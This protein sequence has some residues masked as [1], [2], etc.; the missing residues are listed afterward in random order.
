MFDMSPKTMAFV[1]LA[2]LLAFSATAT[3]T[4][5]FTGESRSVL[6]LHSYHPTLTWTQ[7][8]QHGIETGFANAL[9]DISF[10]VEFMDTKRF[11]N[12]VNYDNLLQTYQHKF[13]DR[14]PDIVIV[15]DNNGLDFL[16][17]HAAQLFPDTPIV[18]CG[19]NNYS[20]QLI[21]GHPLFTGIAEEVA[22]GETIKIALAVQPGLERLYA[23]GA[24]SATWEHNKSLLLRAAEPFRKR[25]KLIIVEGLDI[26]LARMHIAGLGPG[27]AVILASS[28]RDEQGELTSFEQATHEISIAGNVPVY[29]CWDFQLGFGILG[30]KLISGQAQGEAAAELALRILSGEPVSQVHVVTKSPNRI[31]FDHDQMVRFN[32]A[33][34]SLPPGS[35][36]I[37]L[38]YSFYVQNR[39][40][41][42]SLLGVLLLLVGIIVALIMSILQRRQAR[43]LL[44]A[45]EESYRSIY[46]ATSDAII[47]CNMESGHVLDVNEPMLRMFRCDAQT[48]LDA[49]L[50][51]L[52]A[53]SLEHEEQVAMMTKG[54]IEGSQGFERRIKR[55]DETLFWAELTLRNFVV[56]GQPRMLCIVRDTT[57]RR[58]EEKI[59][60]GLMAELKDKNSELERFA[61]TVSHDLK[62]PIITIRGFVDLLREG[63]KNESHEQVLIDLDRVDS[64]AVRMN[65]LLDELLDLSRIGRGT[66]V[67]EEINISDLVHEAIELVFGQLSES[68]GK[69]H[70]AENFPMVYGERLRLLEIFQNLIGN[71]TKFVEP[72]QEPKIEV[73]VR[74]ENG[75]NVF[76]VSDNG[77]GIQAEYADRVFNLF[78]Q[79]DPNFEGTGVGLALVKRIVEHHG[80]DIWVES[81]GEGH[82]TTFCFTLPGIDAEK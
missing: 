29:G 72:G 43:R 70:V 82:G 37:N 79:L 57:Q 13:Q 26:P 63:I 10:Q 42:W 20:P 41:V 61:Y 15:S 17:D 76:F 18:F 77:I 46:N 6:V 40:L 54:A 66:S 56:A 67:C 45:S 11:P 21:K 39:G 1:L 48:A 16:L 22:F 60:E 49:S 32:I 34:D 31:M 50:K 59:R 30:G 64:A 3:A 8:I 2:L 53:D 36:Q 75:R 28:Y 62:S 47:V 51:R 27:D 9:M 78:E 23:Y 4:A 58:K 73:G 7:S 24:S 25:V 35:V 74:L 12:S 5:M 69:V 38:P 81:D 52:C 33:D 55:F 44:Q 65:R 19:V 14:I 68:G 80:G 71:A